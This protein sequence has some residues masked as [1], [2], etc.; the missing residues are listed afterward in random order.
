MGYDLRIGVK[1]EGLDLIAVIDEPECSSPTYNLAEMFRSCT[2]WDFECGKWYNVKEV[3]TKIRKGIDELKN[4]WKKYKQFEPENGWGDINSA[5]EAL[6][7]LEKCIA[8]NVGE[9][10]WARWQEIPEE[11]LWVSW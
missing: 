9:T 10:S 7:S 2:G 5:L 4:N 1:V 11:N 8:D 6:E 3:R